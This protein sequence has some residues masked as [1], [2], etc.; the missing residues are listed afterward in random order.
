MPKPIQFGKPKPAP[1]PPKPVPVAKKPPI[2]APAAPPKVLEKPPAPKP[3]LLYGDRTPLDRQDPNS[4]IHAPPLE[5]YL[6]QIIGSL[7]PMSELDRTQLTVILIHLCQAD[8]KEL[9]RI[10]TQYSRKE[11]P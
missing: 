9:A 3:K 6:Q 4:S 8:R 2:P 7:R 5:H 1:I 10:L 11:K